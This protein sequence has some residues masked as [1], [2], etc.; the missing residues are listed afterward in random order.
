MTYLR[1]WLA[2]HTE[3]MFACIPLGLL[4]MLPHLWQHSVQVLDPQGWER[5]PVPWPKPTLVLHDAAS[6]DCARAIG[7]YIGAP[8]VLPGAVD[9]F[10]VRELPRLLTARPGVIELWL[11]PADVTVSHSSLN[12]GQFPDGM[13]RPR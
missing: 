1:A 8:W 5:K 12:A 7:R 2:I 6:R 4:V 13:N 11:P 3:F 9:P 10:W